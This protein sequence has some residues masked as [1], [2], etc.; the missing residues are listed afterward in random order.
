MDA[1]SEKNLLANHF[2]PNEEQSFRVENV[3][4]SNLLILFIIFLL[5]GC[6]TPSDYTGSVIYENQASDLTK[7]LETYH[8]EYTQSSLTSCGDGPRYEWNEFQTYFTLSSTNNIN[9]F[10]Q[11]Y[12]NLIRSN[13]TAN[14]DEIRGDDGTNIFFGDGLYLFHFDYKLKGFAGTINAHFVTNSDGKIWM[15]SY[16]YEQ[17]R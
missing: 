12:D 7:I 13:L 11:A 17:K 14:A 3:R 16:F 8:C 9:D 15:T 5:A 6:S 1:K 10:V 2:L 4:A